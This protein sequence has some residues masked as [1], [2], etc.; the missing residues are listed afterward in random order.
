MALLV[1]FTKP[2]FKKTC[3]EVLNVL[4]G[5]GRPVYADTL[6]DYGVHNVP[7]SYEQI[8]RP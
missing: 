2:V 6:Y 5:A 3:Y 7:L 4:E 8:L 1:V